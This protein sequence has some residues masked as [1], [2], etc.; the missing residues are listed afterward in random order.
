MRAGELFHRMPRFAGEPPGAEGVARAQH[1]GIEGHEFRRGVVMLEPPGV[2]HGATAKLLVVHGL[3]LADL[4]RFEQQRSELTRSLRE[5]DALRLRGEPAR[6][7]I[8]A[9]KMIEHAFA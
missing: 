9:A 3:K 6:F 1:R 5:R 8:R 4:P 7:R 2:A